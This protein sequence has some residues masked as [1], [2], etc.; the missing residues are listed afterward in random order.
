MLRR[1]PEPELMRAAAQ[2]RAY[3]HADFESAHSA[4]PRLFAQR[5]PNAPAR[6]RVLDLG[7]GPCDVTLRFARA[8]PGWRFDAVDGSAAMLRYARIALAREPEVA[9][10]IRLIRGRVP[11]VR[12]PARAYDVILASSFL[13]HLHDPQVLWQTIRRCGRAGACVFIADLRR[14]TSRARARV[15]TRRYAAGEPTVL[16]RDFFNSLLAAFTPDEVRAQ[17]RAAGLTVLKVEPIGNRHLIVFG[18]V[19]VT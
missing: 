14:P 15:L 11:A 3:A 12:L 10:R 7:C 9:R 16:Q 18:R 17:L 2:A 5:F 19:Q 6:A 1:V 8:Y 13:H 4:Y